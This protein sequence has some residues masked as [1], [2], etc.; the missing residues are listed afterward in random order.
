MSH[1][2]C[3][4]IAGFI[5]LASA[6]GSMLQRGVLDLTIEA[7]PSL[8]PMTDRV[9]SIDRQQLAGALAQAGLNFPPQVH[10]TLIPEDDSR[11]RA[12][13]AGSWA[14]RSTPLTS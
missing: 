7:P 5:L 13:P 11:A 6:S 10:V 3:N 12:T 1:W 8:A 9:R 14:G 4:G 2:L